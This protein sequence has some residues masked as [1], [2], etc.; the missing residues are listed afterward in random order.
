M[1]CAGR[2]LL[3]ALLGIGA[4]PPALAEPLVIE[5]GQ[6]RRVNSH[7]QWNQ[8]C[9][10]TGLPEIVMLRPPVG[11]TIELRTEPRPAGRTVVGTA[12]C[13]G[14]VLPHVALY[15]RARR[16]FRGTDGFEY[17]VIFGRNP[18][19]PR[20]VEILVREAGRGPAVRRT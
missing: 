4:A 1:T 13:E 12:V 14:T 9:E 10:S 17:H 7:A 19:S 20:R 3:L 2:F 8:A 18:P 11:G 6:E 5:A 16:D 15:Y